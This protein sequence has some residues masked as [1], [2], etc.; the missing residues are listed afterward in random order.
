[1]TTPNNDFM[2]ILLLV[3]LLSMTLVV[4]WSVRSSGEFSNEV[5]TRTQCTADTIPV[6]ALPDAMQTCQL[7]RQETCCHF[8]I[9]LNTSCKIIMY[10]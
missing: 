4:I 3:L 8:T 10:K 6:R 2:Q 1:M 5:T 9:G 7:V